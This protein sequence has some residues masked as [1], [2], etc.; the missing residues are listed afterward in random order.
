MKIR[1]FVCGIEEQTQV[2]KFANRTAREPNLFLI[3]SLANIK[4]FGSLFRKSSRHAGR[5][6]VKCVPFRLRMR[7]RPRT[8]RER[9][10]LGQNRT[11]A[12]E[13]WNLLTDQTG[14]SFRMPAEKSVSRLRS[15]R[16]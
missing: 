5:E 9:E 6:A 15:A 4:F 12:A 13:Y 7:A 8:E 14:G 1:P 2:E 16:H 10:W 3:H 11:D